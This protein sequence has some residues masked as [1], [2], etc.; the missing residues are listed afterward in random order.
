MSYIIDIDKDEDD[1]SFKI[2]S[3]NKLKISFINALRRI[4]LS[5]IPIYN[6]SYVKINFIKNTCM[7]D[8][9]F[10]KHRLGLVSIKNNLKNLDDVLIQINK[11]NTSDDII[12]VYLSD[13]IVT[14]NDKEIKNEDV[15]KYPTTLITKLKPLQE[16]HIE[17]TLQSGIGRKDARFCPVS[18]AY[19]HFDY[20]KNERDFEKDKFDHPTRYV[21]T[22][23]SSGQ[24]T[25]KNILLRAIDVLSMKLLN[26]KNDIK[27]NKG[28]IVQYKNNG[29]LNVDL[30]I[31]NENDTIGN[32]ITQYIMDNNKDVKNCGYHIPHPLKNLLI[33]RLSYQ[34]NSRENIN[35][36]L[37]E[38]IDYIINLLNDFKKDCKKI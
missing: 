7:F 15:F 35:N 17:T 34:D 20:D 8:N 22:I 12:S 30:H 3:Q 36:I 21:F 2:N 24:L 37:F 10:I 26:I 19:Y 16:I 9:E 38:T 4:M 33:I 13:F 23:E 11:K 28:Q 29:D 14:I 31:T 6:I 18:S 27:N 25:P 5:D 32:L 1:L